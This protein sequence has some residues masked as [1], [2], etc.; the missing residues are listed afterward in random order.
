MILYTPVH[1][2]RAYARHLFSLARISLCLWLHAVRETAY[3]RLAVR[4][5]GK[6]E[7]R[8][9]EPGEEG[10]DRLIKELMKLCRMTRSHIH[11][12]PHG[13]TRH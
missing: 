8:Q 5:H 10:A 7:K 4:K 6:N 1:E 3:A 13:M 12:T 2:A 9:Q 11:T